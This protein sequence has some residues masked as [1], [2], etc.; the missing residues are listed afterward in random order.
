MGAFLRS[1]RFKRTLD[2]LPQDRIVPFAFP[3]WER[4]KVFL[5]RKSGWA[6]L[7]CAQRPTAM[8]RAKNQRAKLC[9]GMTRRLYGWSRTR[10]RFFFYVSWL[11]DGF[12]LSMSNI[13]CAS[14]ISVLPI[15]ISIWCTGGCDIIVSS[16]TCV[17]GML[18]II[19]SDE[20]PCVIYSYLMGYSFVWWWWIDSAWFIR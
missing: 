1:I 18:K 2:T 4:R 14:R 9:R 5:C 11:H 3:W 7:S 12:R 8:W 10:H 19:F 16:F 17:H 15:S 20:N 6:L 13:I